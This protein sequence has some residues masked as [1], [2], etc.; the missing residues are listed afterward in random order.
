MSIRYLILTL[1]LALAVIGRAADEPAVSHEPDHLVPVDP[2]PGEWHVR[3]SD[4]LQSRFKLAFFFF[5][6][7]VVRPSFS[8]EYVVRLHGAKDDNQ[9]DTT[10]KFFLTY[11]AADKSIWYS[12]PENNDK[13][14]QQK[15]SIATTTVEVPRPLAMRIQQLWQRMLL[16]TRYTE[17]SGGG[18]DGVTYEFSTWCVYGETWSPQE[19]K[20][21]LLL[22]ELG[23]SLIAYCKAA[24]AERPA[25]AREIENKAAQL[26][27]YLNEHQS[28]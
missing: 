7:M 16:R 26:E 14:K 18:V 9:C 6:Q 24:P 21:P 5:A 27:N 15:V 13:K 12:M 28:K 1:A 20:S 19:R 11:S 25:A 22:I 4:Q 10:N 3:Y 8:G 23:K 17:E 2:Y